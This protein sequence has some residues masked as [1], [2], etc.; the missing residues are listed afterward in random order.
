MFRTTMPEATV[1]EHGEAD[2]M[3]DKIGSSEHILIP[4]PTSDPRNAQNRNQPQLGS[5]IAGTANQ[6]HAFRPLR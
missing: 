4:T 3:P 6:R 2:F 1:Y 5:L